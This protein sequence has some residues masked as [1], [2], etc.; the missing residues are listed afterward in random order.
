M[1]KGKNELICQDKRFLDPL[2]PY[3]NSPLEQKAWLCVAFSTLT[4]SSFGAWYTYNNW[5]G[6]HIL[7]PLSDT[8]LALINIHAI[9]I[10]TTNFTCLFGDFLCCYKSP[11]CWHFPPAKYEDRIVSKCS[12]RCIHTFSIVIWYFLNSGE[13]FIHHFRI[14]LLCLIFFFFKKKA[15]LRNHLYVH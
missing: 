2:R 8:I 4:T 14:T 6:K 3:L 13:T 15:H 7:V 9:N 10:H 5:K 11:D 12:Q 1:L